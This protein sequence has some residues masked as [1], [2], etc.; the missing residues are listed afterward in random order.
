MKDIIIFDDII[1]CKDLMQRWSITKNRL[2]KIISD[3]K[4]MEYSVITTR[5]NTENAKKFVCREKHKIPFFYEKIW[6]TRDISASYFN[7][8][9]IVRYENDN[10]LIILPEAEDSPSERDF[11]EDSLCHENIDIDMLEKEYA[12]ISIQKN[13]ISSNLATALVTITKIQEKLTVANQRV[14]NLEKQLAA[15]KLQQRD[16]RS[17]TEQSIDGWT[18]VLARLQGARRKAAMLAI[19]KWKGK[20]HQQAF[21]SAFPGEP[22]QNAKDYVSKARETAKTIA[23]EFGLTMPPWRQ[24]LQ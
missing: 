5:I 4:I 7:M 17:P 12:K 21:S 8:I 13:E 15:S 19:E 14:M 20:S 24:D 2:V 23:A 6:V 1:S 16:S 3:Y 22:S 11:E 18:D 10:P 9:D